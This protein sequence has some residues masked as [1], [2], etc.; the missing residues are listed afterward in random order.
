M[1][2]PLRP[3]FFI[4]ACMTAQGHMVPVRC[5]DLIENGWLTQGGALRDP[6]GSVRKLTSKG[7]HSSSGEGLMSETCRLLSCESVENRSEDV[8]RKQRAM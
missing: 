4:L 5:P 8:E 3:S 1:A 7:A 6:T 2:A